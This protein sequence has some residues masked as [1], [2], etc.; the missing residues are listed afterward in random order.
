MRAEAKAQAAPRIEHGSDLIVVQ[1]LTQRPVT[2]SAARLR[3]WAGAAL[4]A[5]H[6]RRKPVG[7]TL[8]LVGRAESRT[9]NRQWRQKDKPTNVLSFPDGESHDENGVLGLGDIVICAPVVNAEAREQGKAAT[10]H[11]AH[12][13]VHGV[14]HLLGYDHV[15]DRDARRMEAREVE[16]L[17]SFGY[18]NPY[19]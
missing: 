12:M 15:R 9:L 7:L 16:I 13:V 17:S 10:A 2:P 18:S 8:R 14:M 5:V 4:H 6:T 1:K 3:I 11:W 19:Q